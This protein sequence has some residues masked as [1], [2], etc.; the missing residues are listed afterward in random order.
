MPCAVSGYYRTL[1]QELPHKMSVDTVGHWLMKCD[2]RCPLNSRKLA[3]EV[4]SEVSGHCRT[5]ADEVPCAVSGGCWLKN[6]HTRCQ[7]NCPTLAVEGPSVV[8]QWTLLDIGLRSA[9][10]DVSGL[11]LLDAGLPHKTSVD[12]IGGWTATQDVSMSVELLDAG[13]RSATQDV[14]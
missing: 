14:S 2:T 4:P 11:I 1:A 7:L 12:T 8:M 10:Q 6:C 5:L 13:S 9:T 3:I